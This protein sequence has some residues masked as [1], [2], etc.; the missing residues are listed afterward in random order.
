MLYPERKVGSR[1]VLLIATATAGVAFGPDVLAQ[2]ATAESQPS[3]VALEEVLVTATRRS[4]SIQAVPMSITA[5]TAATLQESAAT[6]FFDYASG[7][8][9][10]AFGFSDT[11]GNAGFANSRQVTIRGIAGSGTTGF[12]IDDTPVPASIDPKVVD[13]SR[14]EVLR[15]PQ[16][17]LYGALSM[18]GTVRM[19]T[20]Q[21]DYAGTSARVHG[22]VSDTERTDSPNYQTDGA[23]NIPLID[24]KLAV[25]VSGVREEDGGYF[26]RYAQDTGTT[27]DNVAQSATSGGQVALLWQ[28]IEGLSLTPRVLYQHTQWN[29]FP[30]ATV[31]Y[32]PSQLTPIFIKPTSFTQAEP[33][34]LAEGVGD[35]WTLSSFDIKYNQPFGTF[36]L[37]SSY[38]KRRTFDLQDDT[39]VTAQLFGTPPLPGLVEAESHPRYQVEELRFSSTFSGPFQVVGGLYWQH[40]N[41]SGVGYPPL[42]IPGL[43][44]ASGGAFGTDVLFFQQGR[45]VQI[46]KSPYAEANYDITSH[47]RATVGLRQ[48]QIQTISGPTQTGGIFGGGPQV[49]SSSV[50][51]KVVTPKYS[52]QYRFSPDDQVYATAAKGF[53]PG[54]DEYISAAVTCGSELGAYGVS[55]G[56]ATVA[57][58]TVWSYEV[59]AKTGWLDQRVTADIAAFRINWSKIQETINLPC[60]LAFLANGGKA[61]SQGGELDINARLT[62]NLSLQ[63]SGGFDDATFTTTVPGALF[64]AG[65]RIPQV[66]RESFQ[67]GVNYT[68]PIPHDGSAFGHLDYRSVGDS[69]STNNSV[70]NP[71]TGR[72]VPLIRP[73]YH[74]LDARTG[75]RYGPAEYAVFVKNLTN[76]V[77]NLSDTTAVALQAVG[78][79]RVAVNQPR[80]VGVEVRYFFH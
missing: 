26:K 18:G 22:S 55:A 10:V 76:E 62:E 12:Y 58:D 72:V 2:E 11:G 75:L 14:I 44:A 43:N 20:E 38:F 46:E 23:L 80:T 16:G 78:I 13:V 6:T 77:V 3:T 66:P 41:N 48:T 65:D 59:G 68:H 35:E 29:G 54:T 17:T 8:P 56:E 25:R 4:E 32:N 28:P 67:I 51:Q 74:I 39:V 79:S 27:V 45:A 31:N 52:L 64:E 5:V 24:G 50:T 63:L 60:G 70:T 57:P 69:W 1:A 9:N 7:I 42:A 19:L 40:L 21:P 33:F 34:N 53:R 15:G 73:G 49:P 37:S 30:F 47:W 36:V 61:V 71:T